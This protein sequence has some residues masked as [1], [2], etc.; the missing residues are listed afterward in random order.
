MSAAGDDTI[1]YLSRNRQL[2]TIRQGDIEFIDMTKFKDEPIRSMG[3][4]HA[5]VAVSYG[6]GSSLV[7]TST[8]VLEGPEPTRV[9]GWRIGGIKPR[10]P[11]I[12]RVAGPSLVLSGNA[13]VWYSTP[14]FPP[15]LIARDVLAVHTSS[16][17]IVAATVDAV[18]RVR[19]PELTA[20]GA[21]RHSMVAV[22][23]LTMVG[24]HDV[25]LWG[26]E[27]ILVGQIRPRGDAWRRNAG[28]RIVSVATARD[29]VAVVVQTNAGSASLRILRADTGSFVFIGK[30][31]VCPALAA[32]GET[33]LICE[34][35]ET[36]CT[37]RALV[38][39]SGLGAW[40][41]PWL[42]KCPDY[43]EANSAIAAFGLDEWVTVVDGATG[44]VL[45]RID[46]AR[47]LVRWEAGSG[48]VYYP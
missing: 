47:H 18:V 21:F 40:T 12:E 39:S 36:G 14:K 3:C 11:V 33:F 7:I 30:F 32:S 19:V 42:P 48:A 4:A 46:V 35:G 24:P 43:L 8:G 31:H 41:G 1:C 44:R 20:M 17:T 2:V 45:S 34:T 10:P 5:S 26:E 28:G 38:S 22:E 15:E 29:R 6:D 37:L 16:N 25:V 9:T 13:E 27:E 23:G